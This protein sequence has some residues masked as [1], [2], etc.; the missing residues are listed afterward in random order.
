MQRITWKQRVGFKMESNLW[1][2]TLF[3]PF[4]CPILLRDVPFLY[5]I[6]TKCLSSNVQSNIRLL[7]SNVQSNIR[8]LSSNVQSTLKHYNKIRNERFYH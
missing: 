5:L 8:L 3:N 4:K 1:K 2:M 6:L 7:S